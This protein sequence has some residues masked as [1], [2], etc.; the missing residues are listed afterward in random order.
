M[1]IN[2]EKHIIRANITES[3][4]EHIKVNQ[5]VNVTRNHSKLFTGKILS[6]IQIP[7]KVEKANQFIKLIFRLKINTHLD[8]TL[9]SMLELLK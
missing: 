6:I 5:D 7:Y 4:L 2:S 8:V 9:I 3:Q 1:Q